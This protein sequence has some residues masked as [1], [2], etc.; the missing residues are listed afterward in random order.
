M[1]F[2]VGAGLHTSTSG[3]YVVLAVLATIATSC[4]CG[5]LLGLFVEVAF[6]VFLGASPPAPAFDRSEEASQSRRKCAAHLCAGGISLIG[7]ACTITWL[8]PHTQYL[9][10][11]ELASTLCLTAL[12]TI[13]WILGHA[14]L[15]RISIRLLDKSRRLRQ[16]FAI[17]SLLV[18]GLSWL[19]LDSLFQ[20]LGYILRASLSVQT[21]LFLFAVLWFYPRTALRR[22]GAVLTVGSGLSLLVLSL[23]GLPQPT[24]SFL[25]QSRGAVESL[26]LHLPLSQRSNPRGRLRKAIVVAR[27]AQNRSFF[28]V[29]SPGAGR[30][31]LRTAESVPRPD[32]VLITID[33]LRPDRLGCYGSGRG[34][35]PNLDAFART[36]SVFLNAF[37]TAPGTTWSMT[38]TLAGRFEHQVPH[39]RL[40]PS[41][42]L[43]IHPDTATIASALRDVGYSTRAYWALDIAHVIP[44]V[45]PSLEQGF[46][47][48]QDV[49]QDGQTL[50]A[51]TIF[52]SF[53]RD[54]ASPADQPQFL[55]AHLMDVH[56]WQRN[57]V[58]SKEGL[59]EYDKAVSLVDRDLGAFFEGL[60]KTPRGR[61]ALVIVTADHGESL[62][63]SGRFYHGFMS[64]MTLRI[65][66]I[67][68]LVDARPLTVNTQASL[69]DLAPTILDTLGLSVDG[70][71]GKALLR[72]ARS[73][74]GSEVGN[75]PVFHE[76]QSVASLLETGVTLLPWQL[77][78]DYRNDALTLLNLADDPTGAR[79]LAGSGLPIEAELLRRLTDF[80]EKAPSESTSPSEHP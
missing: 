63:E 59:S 39:L 61:R 40:F 36:S 29:V 11:S 68:R 28:S 34:L 15:Y 31:T 48:V 77:F 57:S 37:S 71:P 79:N 3:R 32:V 22:T 44:F 62:G 65:P 49:V 69:I 54:L 5:L 25:I 50:N 26:T 80:Y 27:E 8:R 78:Y 16:T 76:S 42:T 4:A 53:L 55:W 38:Q 23:V 10:A 7:L 51:T 52:N 72:A 70:F 58:N 75:R 74:E 45:I 13:P 24:R 14:L 43:T 47:T 60:N 35:M 30:T 21:A 73:A 19:A 46:H 6:H 17:V 18:Y 2:F 64:P 12:A 66:L 20:G 1:P 33:S 56:F 9:F 41:A 67:I